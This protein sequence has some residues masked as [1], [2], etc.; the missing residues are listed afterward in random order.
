MHT[1][2]KAADLIVLLAQADELQRMDMD[3]PTDD[4][5]A[6]L[7]R[8][9]LDF[10]HDLFDEIDEHEEEHGEIEAVEVEPAELSAAE[11]YE[12]PRGKW[13]DK[14]ERKYQAIKNSV[15][16][17]GQSL[18]VAQRIAAATVNRDRSRRRR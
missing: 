11:R 2:Q 4:K 9:S 14:D 6:A 10:A 5:I 16:D 13:T 8:A 7:I 18:R 15:L 1:K 17:S 3:D 12:N